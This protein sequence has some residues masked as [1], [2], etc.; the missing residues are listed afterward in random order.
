MVYE[1]VCVVYECVCVVCGGVYVCEVHVNHVLCTAHI[2]KTD[3]KIRKP[4]Y[5]WSRFLHLRKPK[6][7]VTP[8]FYVRTMLVLFKEVFCIIKS[9]FSD[10]AF[11]LVTTTP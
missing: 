1:C 11:Q 3:A 5:R 4:F 6:T 10:E 2:F 8:L 9:W 7:Q